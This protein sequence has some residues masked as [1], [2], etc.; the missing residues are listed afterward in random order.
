VRAVPAIPSPIIRA[1]IG[2]RCRLPAGPPDWFADS[3]WAY[4]LL[5][6]LRPETAGSSR[7]TDRTSSLCP[8]SKEDR[9]YGLVVPFPLLSTIC[10][11]TAVKVPYPSAS[12]SLGRAD[13]HHSQRTPSQAHRCAP[14]ELLPGAAYDR[15]GVSPRTTTRCRSWGQRSARPGLSGILGMPPDW[16]KAEL[17]TCKSPG[18]IA[19]NRS[20][21]RPRREG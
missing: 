1:R 9:R 11:Q 2:V 14:P 6:R 21:R 13:F 3:A 16:R 7:G 18:R 8:P 12:L 10:R 15:A 20:P 5:F 19:A 17:E 4:R